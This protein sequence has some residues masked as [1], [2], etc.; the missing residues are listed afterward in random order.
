MRKTRDKATEIA[1]KS[2]EAKST[3]VASWKENT[4]VADRMCV[5]NLELMCL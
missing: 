2:Q 1:V 4:L 3:Y 5:I